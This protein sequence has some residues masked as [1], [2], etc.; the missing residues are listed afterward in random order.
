LG[1]GVTTVFMVFARWEDGCPLRER[2]MPSRIC[3]RFDVVA[4]IEYDYPL[5]ER[6]SNSCV[7]AA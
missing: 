6:R 5:E 7:R 3:S 4:I 1:P 2:D